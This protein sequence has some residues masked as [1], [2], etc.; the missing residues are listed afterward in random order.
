MNK[1]KIAKNILK[2]HGYLLVA[3]GLANATA[4]FVATKIRL[5][6]PFYFLSENPFPEVGFL[7][8]YLLA[9][10]VGTTLVIGSRIEEFFIF[11]IV[12]IVMHLIPPLTLILMYD[13]IHQ[14][15]GVPTII[16]SI[17][18]HATF[19]I[20]EIIALGFYFLGDR[21]YVVAK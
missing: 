19:I 12:G 5:P 1:R 10:L 13:Q 6:G 7:Q 17:S 4:S 9:A 21:R 8:A 11:D 3:L 18:I 20:L 2:T 15:M 14:V 16:L